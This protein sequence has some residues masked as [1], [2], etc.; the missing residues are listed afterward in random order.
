MGKP[1]NRDEILYLQRTC[2][3]SGLYNG[4]IDGKWSAAVDQ[5]EHA[6]AAKNQALRTQIGQFD[7]RTEQNIATLMPSAQKAART[8]MKAAAAFPLTVRIISGSRTYAEQDALFAIGRTIQTNKSPVTNAR[9]G[10][11]N[12]NFGVA[13]DVGIFD[14]AGKYYTGAT[15]AEEKAYVDLGALIKSQVAKLEWGGDWVKFVD[16]PHYQLGAGGNTIA[17]VRKLFEAGQPFF[18]EVG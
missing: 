13:W 16:R 18:T 5:A 7:P 10:Q 11:S 2:A 12:H 17:Q 14:S 1:L 15:K 6:L 4:P 8:F 9:G 3:C